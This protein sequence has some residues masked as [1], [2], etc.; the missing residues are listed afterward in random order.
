MLTFLKRIYYKLIRMTP[1]KMEM[2]SYWKTKEAVEAKVTTAKDKSIIMQLEGEK[3]PFPTFP[4]GHLLF[5]NL[6]KLKHEIKNQIFNE[7]WYKLENNIPKQEIIE[8]IKN[9]LYNEIANIAETLR[10][11]ML[12]P[13]SMTP[14]VKEIHR[15]WGIVSPKT[16][17]L[18]DYLCFILQEDDA[19]RFRVQW[20][21]NWFG[22]LAKL[23]PCKTF[24]YALKQLE[25][26]EIIG[27]MKERQRLLRRILMLA[28]EDK[29]IKQDFINLFKEINWNKVKLTKADKFHFRGK[30]FRVDYDILEY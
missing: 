18:R 17:V 7:S 13:E 27:D 28:L 26:G 15:A 12:P 14:S 3:Y 5:G 25:H 20:L 21:V 8:N 1:D 9:K 6:S 2:V 19:Y 29:T 24:D 4:R 11:D 22:W 10:Y 30:Y 23:S 16:G